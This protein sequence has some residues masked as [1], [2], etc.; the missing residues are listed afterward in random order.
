MV[1]RIV[2]RTAPE[3]LAVLERRLGMSDEGA[4]FTER[5]SQWVIEDNF[6]GPR[7]LWEA[8]GAQIVS[9]VAPYETAKLRMLNG[10]HSLLA[11]CGLRAEYEFVH[12]AVADPRLRAL[13]E[14]LMR[15]EAALTIAHAPDQDLGAYADQLLARF[16]DPALRH[17]LA[18]IAMDGSQKIPQRWLDTLAWHRARS[19]A[20]PALDEALEAWLW[21]LEDGRFV[22]DPLGDELTAALSDGGAPG[23]RDACFSGR[24]GAASDMAGLIGTPPESLSAHYS[25]TQSRRRC[26]P[27]SAISSA[28]SP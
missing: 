14:R 9:D 1:D 27:A 7:P 21:H 22:D 18:Q 3:D 6:V 24:V 17:R 20:T 16:A 15:K 19:S 23:L 13:A 10:A 28:A 26:L 4:V 2:P 5:F 8:H 25:A 11:F 12:E